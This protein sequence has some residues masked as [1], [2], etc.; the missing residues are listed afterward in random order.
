M[1]SSVSR[2]QYLV[3]LNLCCCSTRWTT[4]RRESFKR[5]TLK[6]PQ[7]IMCVKAWPASTV[8]Q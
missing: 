5:L 8:Q 3:A 1:Q 6:Q 2:M 4:R 7:V